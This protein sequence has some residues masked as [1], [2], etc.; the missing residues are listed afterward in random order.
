[1][2]AVLWLGA[3]AVLV[4][5]E[6]L[7]LSVVAG[8]VGAGAL[9]AALAAALGAPGVVQGLVFVGASGTLLGVA[10]EPVQR[11]L[12]R[13]ADSPSADP[14]ALTGATAVV[15]ERVSETTGQVRL[16]GELWRARPYAGTGPVEAGAPVS[17]AAVEG[18]T[19]LVFSP[20]LL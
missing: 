8:F 15:V 20:D 1:V 12:A 4:V 9:A 14:R 13:G 19:L 2:D 16:H 18:A 5:V 3:A 10:R 17:V 7:T 6:L 11:R